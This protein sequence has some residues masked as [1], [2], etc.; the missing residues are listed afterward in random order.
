VIL[1]Y[2]DGGSAKSF[3]EELLEDCKF[4]VT[5]ARQ[6]Y[7]HQFHRRLRPAVQT[8]QDL[9][10]CIDGGG[11]HLAFRLKPLSYCA[12]ED[13]DSIVL[14][15]LEKIE[16]PIR[17]TART[18]FDP[19]VALRK[20]LIA[21]DGIRPR[22][23]FLRLF[24]RLFSQSRL[25]PCLPRPQLEDTKAPRPLDRW[26]S[27]GQAHPNCI[28]LLDYARGRMERAGSQIREQAPPS[29]VSHS[30]ETS[31]R[32]QLADTLSADLELPSCCTACKQGSHFW[33]APFRGKRNAPAH[34]LVQ[35]QEF[36]V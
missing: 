5:E 10:R 12:A 13:V 33:H 21:R 19:R 1:S 20:W 6:I 9:V 3:S 8:V 4:F 23:L 22:R 34:G 25:L 29:A 27:G 18:R 31:I 16:P 30:P 17:R 24:S 7:L 35:A 32:L 26:R 14:V 36:L 15:A 28:L 2:S 11:W